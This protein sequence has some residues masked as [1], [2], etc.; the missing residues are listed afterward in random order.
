M[1]KYASGKDHFDAMSRSNGVGWGIVKTG[2]EI[3]AVFLGRVGG[4]F[5]EAK[6]EELEGSEWSGERLRYHLQN[7]GTKKY[8]IN[9]SYYYL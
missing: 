3:R 7:L 6:V 5:T 4:Q 8:S 2:R 1:D 9:A